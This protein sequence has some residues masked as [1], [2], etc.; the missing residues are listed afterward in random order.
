MNG[1]WLKDEINTINITALFSLSLKKAQN[2]KMELIAGAIFKVYVDG[3]LVFFGPM[4]AAHHYARKHI[5]NLNGKDIQIFV[6]N[7]NIKTFSFLKANPYFYCNVL[8]DNKIYTSSDFI[9][10]KDN[11]RIKKV[12]RYSYQRGFV[13]SYIFNDEKDFMETETVEVILP[14]II[15]NI[16]HYPHLDIINDCKE[17]EQGYIKKTDNHNIPY[18][19]YLYQI[20][21][22]L[23]GYLFEECQDNPLYDYVSFVNSIEKT[24]TEYHLFKFNHSY[25][26]FI[27][28]DIE[29]INHGNVYIAFEEIMLEE[30][31]IKT[32]NILRNETNNCFKYK[33][34]KKGTY[35]LTSFEPY[36]Y[37]YVKI[38]CPINSKIKV[39]ITEY[40]NPDYKNFK[41]NSTDND[42]NLIVEAAKNSFAA[43]AVDLLTDCP[44]R[45]RSG[46]LSD[47][48]F[49][50]V[51]E[52][53]LTGSNLVEK[54][55]LQNY[56]LADTSGLPKGMIPM[57]YPSDDYDHMFIPNWSMWYIMQIIKSN[58]KEI[59]DEA[60]ERVYGIFN[61]FKSKE[62]E[63]NLL[64]NLDSWVF[65]EWSKA[66]DREHI[67]GVNIP[68]NIQYQ[69]ILEDA[70]KLYNEPQWIEKA[71]KIRKYIKENAFDGLLL[72]DNLIR[73]EHN[74]LI[75][76]KNF[77]ETCQ[78][79]AFWFQAIDKNEYKDL[80]DLLI[81]KLG[82]NKEKGFMEYVEKP[83]MI[84]G[85]Y[86]R[87]DLLMKDGNREEIIKEVKYYFKDMAKLTKTLWEHTSNTASLNHA[88]AS[89][90]L[91]YIIFAL[92]SYDVM[93]GTFIDNKGIGIDCE[94]SIPLD[95]NNKDKFII[96]SINNV[97]S[98]S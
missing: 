11:R 55:F 73:D 66:N 96:K 78:Y 6:N 65:V 82:T 57:N 7:P 64:E 59:I 75:K 77:T 19:R 41:F 13:E 25:T 97:I 38:I 39:S 68:S 28:L 47:S 88:F 18:Q 8:A 3:K 98:H 32:L 26:G 48:Y 2:F 90:C 79:Y 20:G 27:N 22:L 92:T 45:E 10:Y 37:Q 52:R 46:W 80:Y 95:I 61:Y 30:N 14:K 54:A 83:N 29:V 94:I 70:G 23:E 34:N 72:V 49:S 44:S 89:Y 50:S 76:T 71:L 62:N 86:M 4:R 16:V 81:N 17:I 53:V 69:R 33:L 63:F 15:D 74:N 1:I 24:D 60:K 21:T 35:H 87:L 93:E 36:T 67:I 43:N 56:A 84:Y 51:A 9:V 85:I 40:V 42:L 91:K 5:L 58:D 12:P 31:G